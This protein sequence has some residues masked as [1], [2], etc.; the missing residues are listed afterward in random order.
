MPALPYAV[1]ISHRVA[2][3][4]NAELRRAHLL[5]M[6]GSHAALASGAQ[7]SSLADSR[8]TSESEH[9]EVRERKTVNG[10]GAELVEAEM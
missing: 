6:S 8:G 2:P 9:N 5:G 10:C 4:R 3:A 1:S 7:S